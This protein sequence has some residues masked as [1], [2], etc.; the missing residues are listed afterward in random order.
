MGADPQAWPA[1]HEQA[2]T[3]AQVTEPS[4]VQ[5]AP[6]K[7]GAGHSQAR[8]MVVGPKLPGAGQVTGHQTPS[9]PFLGFTP[10]MTLLTVL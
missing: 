8:Y 5:F 2:M 7:A 3:P 9:M 6:P 4:P 10:M 1:G